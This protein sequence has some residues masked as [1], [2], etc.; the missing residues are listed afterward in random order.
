VCVNK[1]F[2]SLF[3]HITL[4]RIY[5]YCLTG[6]LSNLKFT[7]SILM[8]LKRQL[9]VTVRRGG[10][11]DWSTV[12]ALPL[13]CFIAT[14]AIFWNN[15][16]LSVTKQGHCMGQADRGAP[17]EASVNISNTEFRQ[18]ICQVYGTLCWSLSLLL[19]Q[20][21]TTQDQQSRISASH[22]YQTG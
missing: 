19:G 4:H 22:H 15:H 18:Y 14:T 2:S 13:N 21:D 20:P 5:Y 10:N 16:Q 1:L 7:P 9:V 11:A 6:I 17:W 3:P 8:V 12:T